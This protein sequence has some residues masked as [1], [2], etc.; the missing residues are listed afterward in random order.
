VRW[1]AAEEV[2][3]LDWVDADRAVV[4]DLVRLLDRG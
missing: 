4:A 3:G 1:V 2:P